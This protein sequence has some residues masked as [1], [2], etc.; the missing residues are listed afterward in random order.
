MRVVYA[1]KYDNLDAICWRYY[2]RSSG[3][4][5]QVLAANPHLA[6]M[7]PI[8]AHGTQVSLPDISTPQNI[9]QSIQLWD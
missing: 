6:N 8:L 7:G 9:K 4:V 2:G 3:V 5:E 1:E